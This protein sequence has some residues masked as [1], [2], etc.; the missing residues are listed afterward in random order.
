MLDA[1]EKKV[2]TLKQENKIKSKNALGQQYHVVNLDWYKKRVREKYKLSCDNKETSDYTNK[3]KVLS[4]VSEEIIQ[5]NGV[6]QNQIKTLEKKLK[7]SNCER[8]K[9]LTKKEYLADKLASILETLPTGIIELDKFGVVREANSSSK[10]LLEDD[11]IGKPWIDIVSKVFKPEDDDCCEVSLK[12]GRKV[13][14]ST[15]CFEHKEGQ[16]IIINDLTLTRKIQLSFEKNKHLVELGRTAA[17][18]AHQVRTPLCSA[19]LYISQIETSEKIEE[20]DR[21][22]AKKA[23]ERLKH[24]EEHVKQILIFA[25]GEIELN[26]CISLNSLYDLIKDYSCALLEYKNIKLV[27][28]ITAGDKIILC[29]VNALVSAIQNI[30]DNSIEASEAGTFILIGIEENS[31]SKNKIVIR[32]EDQGCGIDEAILNN[33]W[34]PFSSNKA[35]GTGIGLSFVKMVVEAHK[36]EICLYSK[37][38]VGTKVEIKLPLG[39]CT[40]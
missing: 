6:L 10:K 4:T 17:N 25:R 14:V 15:K 32:I 2:R 40:E 26:D 18:L 38:Q 1:N 7:T 23:K 13:S 9:E 28:D 27:S 29:N 12:N 20:S 34:S 35:N 37:K 22:K 31:D 36:G 11:L 16:I 19:L 3:Y 5:F 24:L 39:T 8:Q 21:F 30:L 33:V